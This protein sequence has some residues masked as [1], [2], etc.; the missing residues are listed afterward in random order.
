MSLKARGN[1]PFFSSSVSYSSDI[2]SVVYVDSI[3]V[4]WFPLLGEFDSTSAAMFSLQVY[5]LYQ[6]HIL[7]IQVST[8]TLYQC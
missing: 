6:E 3:L 4:Y 1:V 5:T 2:V 7:L 8:V